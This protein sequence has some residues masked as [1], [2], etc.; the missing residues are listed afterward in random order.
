MKVKIIYP[1]TKIVHEERIMMWAEDAYE[2]GETSEKPR[3]VEHAIILLE[4]AGIITVDHAWTE[5]HA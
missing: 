4:D 2:N 5:R 1:E 3:D